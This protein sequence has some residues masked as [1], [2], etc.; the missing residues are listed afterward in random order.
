MYFEFSCREWSIQEEA[1]LIVDLEKSL[2]KQ[3]IDIDMLSN[4]LREKDH[5]GT[6]QISSQVVDKALKSVGIELD[7]LVMQRWIKAAGGTGAGTCKIS[8]LI[9]I[10]RKATSPLNDVVVLGGG[11]YRR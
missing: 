6:D 3:V 10:M 1:K 9:E 5:K 7:K 8:L 2:G 4:T 11:R